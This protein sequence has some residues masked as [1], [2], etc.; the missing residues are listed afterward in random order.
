MKGKRKMG[1][2]LGGATNFKHVVP[3]YMSR[4]TVMMCT[5]DPNAG[6]IVER[7]PITSTIRAKLNTSNE[8]T[9]AQTR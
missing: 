3:K 4:L 8:A 7:G 6:A 5:R 2:V 9:R 1:I